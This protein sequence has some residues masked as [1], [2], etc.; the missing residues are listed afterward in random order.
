MPEMNCRPLSG[1]SSPFVR[2]ICNGVHCIGNRR[3]DFKERSNVD[4]YYYISMCIEIKG[5]NSLPTTGFEPAPRVFKRWKL[6]PFNPHTNIGLPS[7]CFTNNRLDT[8]GIKLCLY[9]SPH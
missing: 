2:V 8:L 6:S 5:M 3:V 4:C 7:I 9:C 1:F